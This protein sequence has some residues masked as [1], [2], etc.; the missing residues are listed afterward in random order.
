M[1]QILQLIKD[2]WPI[3]LGIIIIIM[4]AQWVV[5][6]IIRIISLAAIIGVVLVLFFQ[7]SPDEVIQMGRQ[8]AVA[9]Q[10]VVD[11]TITPVLDKELKDADISFKEDGTYEVKTTNIR[12][13][14]KKGESKATVYYKDEEWEV[15][16]GQLSKLFQ[17]RLGK[18]EQESKTM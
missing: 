13:V 16:I 8:A 2:Y 18:A 14:G 15:N 9:T 3:A 17:D 12:I 1:D 4:A 5:R 7:F 10:E 6:S 11:Q